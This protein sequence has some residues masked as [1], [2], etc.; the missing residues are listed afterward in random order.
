MNVVLVGARGAGKT[1]IAPLLAAR[2]RR[3]WL[4]L[5]RELERRAGRSVREIFAADGEPAFRTLEAAEFAA[6]PEDDWI[7]ATGGGIVLRPENRARLARAWCVWLVADLDAL[8]RRTAG[9][10]NRP[11]L[12]SLPPREEAAALLAA[13]TPLYQEVAR[14]RFVADGR[15]PAAV[16]DDIAAAFRQDCA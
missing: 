1:T 7:V 6:V 16:A 15:T 3:P 9:D 8:V 13:R 11:A 12:T 5:D 4:D 10:G 14:R 2:L